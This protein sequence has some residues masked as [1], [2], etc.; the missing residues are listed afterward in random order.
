MRATQVLCA[1]ISVFTV[2]AASPESPFEKLARLKA[3]Y[4]SYGTPL[5]ARDVP[6]SAAVV[7][8]AYYNNKSAKFA[9]DGKNFPLVNFDIGESY[10]GLLPISNRSGETRQLFFWFFPA[11]AGASKNNGTI[12]EIAAWFNGGPG[13]SSLSGLLTENGPFLWQAGTIAPTVNPYAWNRLTNYVWIEQPVGVGYSTGE[14][15][16]SNELELAEQFAGFWKNFVDTFELK[17]YRTYLVS[18]AI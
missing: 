11:V 10:A 17:G 7:D 8:S 6:A 15:N 14:P 12:K 3:Q 1:I 4:Q 2:A 16:I 18:S 9:V 13:C 5:A